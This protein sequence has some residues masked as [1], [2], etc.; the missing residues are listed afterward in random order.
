MLSLKCCPPNAVTQMLSPQLCHPNGVR[1]RKRER[2]PEAGDGIRMPVHLSGL[3]SQ[4]GI[5]A[6]R[7][8]FRGRAWVTPSPSAA[9]CQQRRPE[10]YRRGSSR[11]RKDR[12]RRRAQKRMAG[13]D[14]LPCWGGRMNRQATS[15]HCHLYCTTA[16][17]QRTG[18][19]F[20][21]KFIKNR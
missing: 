17:L 13:M 1:P 8:G 2:K 18:T 5:L 16:T 15:G 14:R 11:W 3:P 10:T 19:M 4:A 9:A 20:I 12:N 6:G 21:L 7:T